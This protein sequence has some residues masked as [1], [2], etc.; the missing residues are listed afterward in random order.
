M[1][2]LRFEGVTVRYGD[3]VALDNLDLRAG[4]GELLVLVGPSGSGKSTALRILAGLEPPSGGA[5]FIGDQDVTTLAPH[6]RGVAMVFQDYALY[7]HLTVA[8]P[9]S[10]SGS[11]RWRGSWNWGI[12]WGGIPTSCPGDSNSASRWPGR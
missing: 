11:R 10:A 7:P 5:V 9:A 8:Q 1:T 2:E 6:R 3:V 12:C 4:A